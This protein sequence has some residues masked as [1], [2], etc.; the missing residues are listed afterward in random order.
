MNYLF[1]VAHPDDEVLGA[2]ATIHRLIREGYNVSVCMLSSQC[3][4]RYD[5]SLVVSMKDS[6]AILGIEKAYVGKFKCLCFKDESHQEM[7]QFIENAIVDSNADVIFT[8]HPT[9]LNNDHYITSLLCQ[10]A[11]RLPQRQICDCN[12]IKAIYFMEVQSSTDWSFNTAW[13]QFRPNTFNEIQ[14]EDLMRKLSALDVYD[15]VIRTAPHP[16]SY[17]NIEALVRYRG[18]QSGFEYAEAFECIFNLG[19]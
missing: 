10:E 14:Y 6:H 7:V 19:V 16:R 1:V 17:E 13:E 9:D 18:S 5:E 12:K 8:H 15:K 3:N 4:T 2:G 11:A